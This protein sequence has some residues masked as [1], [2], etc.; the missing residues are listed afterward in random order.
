M[1]DRLDASRR[2]AAAGRTAERLSAAALDRL[3]GMALWA[4]EQGADPRTERAAVR[5]AER[6][7]RQA[8]SL[9]APVPRQTRRAVS[10]AT[11]FALRWAPEVVRTARAAAEE[12][13]AFVRSGSEP[14]DE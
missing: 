7:V 13:S 4:L 12:T 10:A 14:G 1:S 2:A 5:S 11:F 9:T 8:R 6:R 3:E